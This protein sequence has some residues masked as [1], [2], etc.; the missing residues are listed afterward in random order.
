[1][2]TRMRSFA[3][4]VYRPGEH[5]GKRYV[6]ELP[7]DPSCEAVREIVERHL[8]NKQMEHVLILV[9]GEPRD[10]FVDEIAEMKGHHANS[11]ATAIYRAD[12]L[13]KHP[14]RAAKSLPVVYGVAVIFDNLIW[15]P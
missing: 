6:E 15:S 2:M 10:M 1:M 8:A 3:Y 13:S 12:W 7:T 11:L 4:T 14:E 5:A 9:D